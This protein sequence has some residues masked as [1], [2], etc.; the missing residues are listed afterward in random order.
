[1]T[2]ARQQ[3][4]KLTSPF[5][6]GNQGF[7]GPPYTFEASQENR[8]RTLLRLCRDQDAGITFAK[9]VGKY[10]I[11]RLTYGDQVNASFARGSEEGLQRK[12]AFGSEVS[13]LALQK[14]PVDIE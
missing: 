5:P 8:H 7:E 10:M 9:P 1:M 3:R 14:C 13:R 11:G 4:F 6:A 2:S 12:D